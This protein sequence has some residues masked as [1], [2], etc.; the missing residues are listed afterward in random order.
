MRWIGRLVAVWVLCTGS[1][2]ATADVQAYVDSAKLAVRLY[3]AVSAPEATAAQAKQFGLFLP[4]KLDNAK[5]LVILIH[6]LDMTRGCWDPMVDQLKPAGYQVA[7]FCY[8]QDQPI[9]DDVRSF[10]DRMDVLRAEHPGVNVDV[11]AF[12]MGSLIAR[13]YIEGS[14]YTGGVDKL[15]MLAPPNHGSQWARLAWAAKVRQHA[16]LWWY[17][18]KWKPSWFITSGLCEA[19]RDLTPGSRFLADLNAL[20]RRAGVKYT[21]VEGDEHPVRRLTAEAIEL[22]TELVPRKLEGYRWVHTVQSVLVHEAEGIRHTRGDS[23][24]PVTHASAS[25]DGVDDVVKVHADHQTMI[26]A[27]GANPPVAWDVVRDRLARR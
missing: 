4:D 26:D 2:A 13:G 5:P 23:D 21:I 3:T 19:G 20:P 8:P 12:S 15:I 17:E 16:Y 6:G 7:C 18:P 11:V 22:S 25:L 9:V 24:G 1:A 10:R 14:N 27:D